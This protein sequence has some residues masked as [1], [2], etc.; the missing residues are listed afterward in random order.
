MLAVIVST[1]LKLHPIPPQHLPYARPDLERPVGLATGF[2]LAMLRHDPSLCR[3]VLA[4]SDIRTRPV[5]SRRTGPYCGLVNVVEVEHS[6]VRHSSPPR[7][8]CPMAAALYVWERAVVVPAAIRHLGSPV[9]RID[10]LGTYACRRM[11]NAAT[12]RP[13]EH[14]TA[15]AIDVA[16]FRLADGRRVTVAGDWSRGSDAERAFLREVRDGACDLFRVVLSPDFN[17]AHRNHFHLDM[18]ALTTCR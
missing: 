18:G 4:L 6:A 10:H 17:A 12:G 15:N 1:A 8:T 3:G 13:S 9:A 2:Q 16:G 14:A 5:A 7:L 11:Y